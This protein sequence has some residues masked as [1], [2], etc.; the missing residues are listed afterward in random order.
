MQK[1]RVGHQ[2]IYVA[3][4]NVIEEQV[5]ESMEV[6]NCALKLFASRFIRTKTKV[7]PTK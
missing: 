3:S 5:F 7:K 6:K 2:Q 1:K 4:A